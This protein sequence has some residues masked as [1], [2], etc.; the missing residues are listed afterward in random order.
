MGLGKCFLKTIFTLF[1]LCSSIL[2]SDKPTKIRFLAPLQTY[3]LF[4]QTLEALIHEF[5][6]SQK[7]LQVELIQKGKH[8]QFLQSLISEHYAST[9]PELALVPES[10]LPTL[11]NLKKMKPFPRAWV[12]E[13]TFLPTFLSQAL[14]A[15]S[16]NVQ[17]HENIR[18]IPFLRFVP[19][20]FFNR[21]LL[22]KLNLPTQSIPASW[23][24]LNAASS[25]MQRAGEFYAVAVPS[26]GESAFYRL[27]GL[28]YKTTSNP[29]NDAMQWILKA[30]NASIGSWV[31]DHP[32]A[33]EALQ[34]FLNQKALVYLGSIEEWSYIQKNANFK[35]DARFP[36]D[37]VQWTGYDLVAFHEIGSKTL[38]FLNYLYSRKAVDQIQGATQSFALT[39]RDKNRS[40]A[41]KTFSSLY[42][43][44]KPPSF[45]LIPPPS[46][47]T[48]AELI[49]RGAE[50]PAQARSPGSS[51]RQELEKLLSTKTQ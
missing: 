10:D 16:S 19:V 4:N 33:E 13:Q 32:T 30:S 28:G 5:N 36:S 25:K 1:F 21:E 3:S 24:E 48:W 15:S 50:N 47:K 38:P 20:W 42:T 39:K 29:L 22:F 41:D 46:R 37:L 12:Q 44:V 18:S 51:Y 9:L 49:W 23:K 7:D 2:A 40:K 27:I 35:F 11:R 31:P 26:S 6:Q 14:S 8:L 34:G 43:R 17:S 45:H